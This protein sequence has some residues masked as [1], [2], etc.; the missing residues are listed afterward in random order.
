MFE[1]DLLSE[2][3]GE[4]RS[5]QRSAYYDRWQ[6]AMTNVIDAPTRGGYGFMTDETSGQ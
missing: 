3:F 4:R 5:D 2:Q 1:N 6:E